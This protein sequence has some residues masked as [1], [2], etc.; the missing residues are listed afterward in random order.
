ME[1]RPGETYKRDG[2]TI[3]SKDAIKK[4]TKQS[5]P[6]PQVTQEE[7]KEKT[8]DNEQLQHIPVVQ[9]SEKPTTKRKRSKSSSTSNRSSNS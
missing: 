2:N 6:K 9:E 1:F 7:I 8:E 4:Q 5:K 3:Y